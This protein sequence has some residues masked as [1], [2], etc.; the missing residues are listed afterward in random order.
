M[1][2]ISVGSEEERHVRSID[3][4]NADPQSLAIAHVEAVLFDVS[5]HTKHN[6]QS[7]LLTSLFE[8]GVISQPWLPLCK[9]T[10]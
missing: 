3:A 2:F 7:V 8:P 6:G 5:L 9:S 1:R 4:F 10:E